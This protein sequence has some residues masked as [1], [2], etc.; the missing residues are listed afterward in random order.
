MVIDKHKIT[1]IIQLGSYYN[2]VLYT[3]DKYLCPMQCYMSFIDCNGASEVELRRSYIPALAN[4]CIDHEFEIF[5]LITTKISTNHTLADDY[6]KLYSIM[7]IH[8]LEFDEPSFLYYLLA[9]DLTPV[10]YDLLQSSAKNR[11]VNL[12]RFAP[13]Y[14][15]AIRIIKGTFTGKTLSPEDPVYLYRLLARFGYDEVINNSINDCS[16]FT[17]A[18]SFA[19]R[20]YLEAGGVEMAI[21]WLRKLHYI[22]SNFSYNIFCY[23]DSLEFVYALEQFAVGDINLLYISI[24]EYAPSIINKNN[25][26]TCGKVFDYVINK[27]KFDNIIFTKIKWKT[28][29]KTMFDF[30]GFTR[31]WAL[32]SAAQRAAIPPFL[33]NG[34]EARSLAYN[35]PKL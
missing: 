21:K 7:R 13:N 1:D 31:I 5:D 2:L 33:L 3:A 17:G 14:G 29:N 35:I 11:D 26:I 10:Q 8:D 30:H 28:Q 25:T 4:Y 32:L 12:D 19:I 9:V 23:C 16:D 20:G 34:N 6:I 15:L 18:I 27:I 22:P 24:L